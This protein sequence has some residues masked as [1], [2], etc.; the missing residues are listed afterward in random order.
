MQMEYRGPLV[1]ISL[2]ENPL[3]GLL[4]SP[5]ASEESFEPERRG[6]IITT[7]GLN[8]VGDRYANLT[9]S[10]ERLVLD[11]GR[12]VPLTFKVPGGIGIISFKTGSRIEHLPQ[13]V[14]DWAESK[15]LSVEMRGG[16]Y[17]IGLRETEKAAFHEIR[18][19]VKL[20][21]VQ[22]KW[23][24]ALWGHVAQ[25]TGAGFYFARGLIVASEGGDD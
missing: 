15:T 7:Y 6:A 5:R 14:V 18:L 13:A 12:V 3:H 1:A 25:P 19:E 10:Q 23:M 16:S 20:P 9:C 17:S 24:A 4:K 22:R 21:G 8:G 2:N 11:A